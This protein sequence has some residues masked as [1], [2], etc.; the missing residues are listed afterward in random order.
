MPDLARSDRAAAELNGLLDDVCEGRAVD[1]EAVQLIGILPVDG[2]IEIHEIAVEDL[3]C[4]AQL[5]GIPLGFGAADAHF[6]GAAGNGSI[7]E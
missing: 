6:T 4:V 1:D 7:N 2:I 3:E 5:Q